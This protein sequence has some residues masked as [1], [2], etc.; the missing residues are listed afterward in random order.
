MEVLCRPGCM[1]ARSRWLWFCDSLNVLR[2]KLQEESLQRLTAMLQRRASTAGSTAEELERAMDDFRKSKQ[3]PDSR[4]I[5][6]QYPVVLT[7]SEQVSEQVHMNSYF[8]IFLKD[9]RSHTVVA[10]PAL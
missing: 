2:R 9:E 1:L 8:P 5:S 10:V 3:F 4:R 7:P 6:N